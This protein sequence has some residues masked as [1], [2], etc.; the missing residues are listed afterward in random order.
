MRRAFT[1]IELVVVILILGIIAAIVV[2]RF[3]ACG[4]LAKDNRVRQSLSV[5][6]DAIELFLAANNRLPGAD[7]NEATF[8]FDLAPY[9]RDF[10]ILPVGPAAAQDD[11]VD[12]DNKL[13]PVKGDNNPTTGWKFYYKTGVLIVNSREDVASN[14]SIQYDDL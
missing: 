14:G 5:V 9:L 12:M 8:K 7:G 13:S 3:M 10:P 4:V 11:S 2:P 1:L 6:R